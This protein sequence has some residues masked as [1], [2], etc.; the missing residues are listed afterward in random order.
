MTR[1]EADSWMADALGTLADLVR[2]NARERGNAAA[3]LCEG[4]RST[5]AEFHGTT[6]RVA[7]GLIAAGITDQARF[8]YLCRNSERVNGSATLC[9]C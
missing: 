8:A 5:F 1:P 6:S 3:F 4:R 7:N 9:I 2:L